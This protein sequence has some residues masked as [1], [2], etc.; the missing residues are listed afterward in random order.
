MALNKEIVGLQAMGKTIKGLWE[1]LN[2]KIITDVSTVSN[3]SLHWF[4]FLILQYPGKQKIKLRNYIMAKKWCELDFWCKLGSPC[5]SL[6]FP[7]LSMSQEFLHKC[8]QCSRDIVTPQVTEW[9]RNLMFKKD[10][11]KHTSPCTNAC[12]MVLATSTMLHGLQLSFPTNYCTVYFNTR[13][14]KALDGFHVLLSLAPISVSAKILCWPELAILV[15]TLITCVH[16]LVLM[17]T[18]AEVLIKQSAVNQRSI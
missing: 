7:L 14:R 8:V 4:Y 16:M 9:L 6:F 2:I 11:H 12:I 17:H 1:S 15:L 13:I 5:P 3:V 18:H 10:W